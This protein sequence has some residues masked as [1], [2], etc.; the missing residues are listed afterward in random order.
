MRVFNSGAKAITFRDGEGV[1]HSIPARTAGEVP[2]GT[3]VTVDLARAFRSTL[4]RLPNDVVEAVPVRAAT[5]PEET[6]IGGDLGVVVPEVESAV[7]PTPPPRPQA[8]KP[9]RPVPASVPAAASV[10][11]TDTPLDGADGST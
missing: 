1:P 10:P 9:R 11:T 5:S 2:E 6:N 4:R 3:P 8:P 7:A